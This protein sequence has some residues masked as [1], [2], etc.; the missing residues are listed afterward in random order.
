MD[1]MTFLPDIFF[2]ICSLEGTVKPLSRHWTTL[3]VSHVNQRRY[4]VEYLMNKDF[5]LRLRQEPV[6]LR[7]IY[8]AFCH[9]SFFVYIDQIC[10]QRSY[11]SAFWHSSLLCWPWDTRSCNYIKRTKLNAKLKQHILLGSWTKHFFNSF[12]Y[13]N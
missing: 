12:N 5:Y 3:V 4:S 2:L 7:L 6:K 10:I 9:Q 11:L 1:N 8:G 13:Q